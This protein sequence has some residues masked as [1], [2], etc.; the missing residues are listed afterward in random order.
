MT[1][2]KFLVLSLGFTLNAWAGGYDGVGNGNGIGSS[3]A[4]VRGELAILQQS[5]LDFFAKTPRV[6]LLPPLATKNGTIKNLVRKMEGV[7]ELSA[8][9]PLAHQPQFL[10]L[11]K[12]NP[13]GNVIRHVQFH[14]QDKPC[15]EAG[16]PAQASTHFV[17]GSPI[18]F[19]VELLS[20]ISPTAL[21]SELIAILMHEMA[22]Q[23]GLRDEVLAKKFQ[24][25]IL[26]RLKLIEL[27]YAAMDLKMSVETVEENFSSYSELS[28]YAGLVAGRSDNDLI[29]GQRFSPDLL[30]WTIKKFPDA[31]KI[32]LEIHKKKR[33]GDISV[34]DMQD[35]IRNLFMDRGWKKTF[36][37]NTPDETFLD[38]Y[39][40]RALAHAY[41]ETILKLIYRVWHDYE[42]SI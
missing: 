4:L 2:L 8:S 16:E 32:L 3:P 7:P 14:V 6:P 19:S 37:A 33:I 23:F 24:Q 41:A 20:K 11:D 39:K 1:C 34:Q 35:N 29:L 18:C 31:E 25:T 22:H 36:E 17:L 27:F 13:V 28:G 30:V 26:N 42:T 9:D 12:S 38:N 10:L 21:R 15:L 40:Q 5:T